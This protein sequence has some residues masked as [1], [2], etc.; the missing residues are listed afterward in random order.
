MLGHPSP[1]WQPCDPSEM[2]AVA[3]RALVLPDTLPHPW[4]LLEYGIAR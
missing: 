3:D 1:P 2:D 4:G